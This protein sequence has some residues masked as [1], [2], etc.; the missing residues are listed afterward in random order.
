MVFFLLICLTY[1]IEMNFVT[2][3]VELWSY[4]NFK[5][6]GT[7]DCHT[8]VNG[9]VTSCCTCNQ[10]DTFMIWFYWK[11]ASYT[12][13][14]D[15]TLTCVIALNNED[16][17]DTFIMHTIVRYYWWRLSDSLLVIYSI[18]SLIDFFENVGIITNCSYLKTKIHIASALVEKWA[19][20]MTG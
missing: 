8:N 9:I 5:S 4:C 1:M 11:R 6:D 17:N 10:W 14:G 19:W 13:V 2:M 16:F 20:N 18:S 7:T 15:A 12:R 3:E